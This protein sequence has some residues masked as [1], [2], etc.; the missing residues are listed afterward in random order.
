MV[1]LPEIVPIFPLPDHVLLPFLPTPYRLFEPAPVAMA[2]A[3][4]EKDRGKRWIVVPRLE[5][6]VDGEVG[7]SAPIAELAV[8]A[9]VHQ[10]L[11]LAGDQYLMLAEG[12]ARV[13]LTEAESDLAY[14][15][16]WVTLAPDEEDSEGDLDPSEV[17][18]LA[19]LLV[20]REGGANLTV[21]GLTADR[22]DP[23]VLSWR[24]AGAYLRDADHRQEILGLASAR[25]RLERLEELLTTMLKRSARRNGGPPE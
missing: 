19:T 8:A 22:P 16:A 25:A 12:R 24:V 17:L 4:L 5:P 11:P 23:A 10:L 18:R 20:G 21:G 9:C 6:V 7:D 3:L 14:R 15:L 1:D 2:Q 13:R